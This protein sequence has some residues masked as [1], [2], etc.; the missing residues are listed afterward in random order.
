[1]RKGTGLSSESDLIVL[2]AASIEFRASKDVL[3]LS[4]VEKL[5]ALYEFLSSL[6]DVGVFVSGLEQP[7]LFDAILQ[8]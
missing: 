2:I 6:Q 7:G 4:V 3:L 1:M 8:Q 5:F